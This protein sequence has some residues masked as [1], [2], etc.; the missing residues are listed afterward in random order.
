MQQIFGYI[1]AVLSIIMVLPYIRDI[2]QKKTQ[3]E[4]ASWLIWSV[5][6]FIAFFSQLMKGATD[7]LWLT[8]GQTIAVFLV[9]LLSLKYGVGGLTRRDA[10]ALIAAGFGLVLWYFTSEPVYA[11]LMVILVDR[12]GTFL[13]ALKAYHEPQSETLITWV[14]SGTSG[15]FGV[16]AV[17]SLNPILIAYPAYIVVAN[18]LIALLLIAG[19]KQNRFR[20]TS[21]L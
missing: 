1:S 14:I 13:T 7:S 16:L 11:L 4:R 12:T 9:L 17:G 21:P 20:K 15:I 10:T 19:R 18:F 5:L 3:P 2:F 6:G 8:V